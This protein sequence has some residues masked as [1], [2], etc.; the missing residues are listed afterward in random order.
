MRSIQ[1]DEKELS[2]LF[3]DSSEQIRFDWKHRAFGSDRS[4]FVRF[5]KRTQPLLNRQLVICTGICYQCC[6]H[7][8]CL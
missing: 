1:S 2:Q 6:G 7:G 5:W 4:R 3:S 8:I